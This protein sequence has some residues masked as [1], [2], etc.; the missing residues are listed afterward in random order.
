MSGM[1]KLALQLI[2]L[3]SFITNAH[4]QDS[5][6]EQD[7]KYAQKIYG[8]SSVA[9]P[10]TPGT[11]SRLGLHP[12]SIQ[13]I[14][15]SQGQTE[16]DLWPTTVGA[17]FINRGNNMMT[18][19]IYTLPYEAPKENSGSNGS[20]SNGS[21]KPPS[22]GTPPE[23]KKK[24]LTDETETSLQEMWD[25]FG[26]AFTLKRPYAKD[27]K[28]GKQEPTDGMFMNLKNGEIEFNHDMV[29][30]EILSEREVLIS[31]SSGSDLNVLFYTIYT[32]D[33]LRDGLQEFIWK[34]KGYDQDLN[35]PKNLEYI[36]HLFADEI[37][38]VFLASSD[39]VPCSMDE[40]NRLMD[41]F[42][43]Q[44]LKKYP[45]GKNSGGVVDIDPNYEY[46]PPP[47]EKTIKF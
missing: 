37:Y 12:D 27:E 17:I 25:N 2:L 39:Y 11:F 47:N 5:V 29:I 10:V 22:S 3:S 15:M 8:K 23:E 44:M 7:R 6:S 31:E 42:I 1:P 18:Y 28:T 46:K 36:K 13:V 32:A 45:P 20:A 33:S 41:E 21:G 34:K 43:K 16:A 38:R 26:G 30:K 24:E 4:A 14:K 9:I 40:Y 35:D 19:C